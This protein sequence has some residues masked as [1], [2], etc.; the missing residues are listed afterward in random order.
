MRWVFITLAGEG[1][2]AD[3][4]TSS[5]GYLVINVFPGLRRRIARVDS[6]KELREAAEWLCQAIGSRRAIPEDVEECHQA[7]LRVAASR[8]GRMADEEGAAT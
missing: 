8:S 5:D 3:L 2:E 7:I 1:G 4:L 6:A